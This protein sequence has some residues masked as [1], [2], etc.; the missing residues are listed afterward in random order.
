MPDARRASASTAVI[1]GKNLYVIDSGPGSERK[2]E[3]MHISPGQVRAVLLTHFHSDHIGDLGELMLKR[4]TAVAA[5]KPLDIIGPTGVG[6]VVDGFNQA[7]VLDTGYRIAHHG[8]EICP[9]DGA[10]GTARPFDFPAGKKEAVIL[11]ED[12]VKITAFEVDHRPVAPAVGY[13]FDYKGRSVVISGDTVPCQSLLDQAKGADVLVHEAL[14]PAI[15]KILMDVN[16]KHGRLN[17]ARIINDIMDYH[18]FSEDAARIAAKAGVGHLL[19]THILPPLPVADLKEAFLG[20]AIKY[21]KGPI[22]VGEDGIAL[23][24]SAGGGE[25]TKRM[26]L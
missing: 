15:N 1:A 25:I 20:D 8:P 19:L 26:L 17:L 2:L 11:E 22:T 16:K 21:Y 6:A 3:L 12:G 9:P 23:S 7:Y 18:T 4:W 10:G 14:Q 24:M 5:R 13:R